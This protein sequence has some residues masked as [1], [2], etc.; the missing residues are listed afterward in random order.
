MKI[1]CIVALLILTV[2][3][4]S[5]AVTFDVTGTTGS[6]FLNPVY[7]P[8]GA[9]WG[10]FGPG[11]ISFQ[12]GDPGT[13]GVGSS[14]LTFAGTPFQ[15]YFETPFK[16]G[17]LTYFNGTNVLQT[18]ATN[19]DLRIQLALTTP[20][21]VSPYYDFGLGLITTPDTNGPIADY[22]LFP[23]SF[24]SGADFLYGG[25]SY[26]LQLTGFQN[27][28]S[29]GYFDTG[30]ELIGFHVDE[31]ATA[32]ADLYGKLTVNRN[33]VP[34]AGTLGLAFSGLVGIL[35]FARRRKLA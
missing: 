6:A 26:T 3:G 32:T 30:G 9:A 8:N 18:A 11:N 13:F 31:G 35:G 25:N 34:E 29:G 23:S 7:E 4:T 10:V 24:G 33:V 16:I 1:L 21:T 12:W 20:T 22:V 28:S 14:K 17:T 2:V 5:F 15:G 27:A 19:I